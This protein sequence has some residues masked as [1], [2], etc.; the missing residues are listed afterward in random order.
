MDNSNSNI[1]RWL[2]NFLCLWEQSGVLHDRAAET[3]I[4][5]IQQY[6]SSDAQTSPW[7]L[8]EAQ[9]LLRSLESR[10]D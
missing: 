2:S 7:Q 8:P 10:M 1:V 3:I 6:Q 5:V 4:S 9:A